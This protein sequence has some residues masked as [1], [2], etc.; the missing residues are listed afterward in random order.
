MTEYIDYKQPL[1]LEEIHKMHKDLEDIVGLI[2]HQNEVLTYKLRDNKNIFAAFI[3]PL[4]VMNNHSLK[5]ML[6]FYKLLNE[7]LQNYLKCS[8]HED[9]GHS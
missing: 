4:I 2:E 8:D 1:S 9:S 7:A 3:K 6:G 5:S